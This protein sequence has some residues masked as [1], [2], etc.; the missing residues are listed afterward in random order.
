MPVYHFTFHAYR[1]WRPDDAK[2]YVKRNRGVLPPDSQMAKWYDD[3]AAQPPAMFDDEHQQVLVDGVLDIAARRDWR[4]HI[5]A[6]D[7]THLHILMSWDDDV[8][9]WKFVHDKL[10]QLLGMMLSK[11]F[12]VRGRKWFVRKGSRKRV[13]DRAHFEYLM[14]EYLPSHRGRQWSEREQGAEQRKGQ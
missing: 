9:E 4:V 1:T 2:G 8:C 12:D 13:K 10:K 6:T 11:H 14:T 3:A 7:T 5:I